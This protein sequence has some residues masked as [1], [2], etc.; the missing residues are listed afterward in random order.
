MNVPFFR[1][2]IGEAEINEVV[3]CLRSGWLTSGPTTKRFETEFAAAVGGKYAVALNSA[4]AALHLAADALGLKPGQAVLV[5]TMT[6]AATAEIVRYLGGIP[7]LVDCD[8]K[9]ANMDLAD[10][11]R[12][13]A[14]LKAGKIPAAQGQSPE[15]VGII[16][17][18]VS[19]L[20]MNMQEVQAFADKHN[21][22]VVEDAAH[23]FPAAWRPAADQPWQRCGEGTSAVA[24]FSFY[25]NK[26]ITTG[27]GG[28]A[29]TDD[30]KLADRIRMM[31]LHGL[32]H[33]AWGRYTGGGSWDYRIVEAGYKYNLTDVA[34]A[35]GVHQLA[36]GEAM[37]VEREQLAAWY[38]EVLAD[39][40]AI[41]VPGVPENRIHSWHLFPIRLK[42]ERLKIDRNAFFAAMREAG[43]GCSVHWRP[44]H[45][46]PYYSDRFGWTPDLFPVATPLWERSISL[47]LFPGMRSDEREYVA[48][49]VRDLCQKHAA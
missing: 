34:A 42:L 24:C 44:L 1:P 12:K 11:E 17:V 22:W 27:E 28:M 2:A 38:R 21:L 47:P 35:I 7:I 10:A 8:A 37:R 16:P 23:A 4:T 5:P 49:I 32:S 20:M 30:Q 13:L 40:D 33:D 3:S 19:G 14:L 15:V 18:H 39:V 9:T 36:R 6:F 46:H 41:E 45:L 43:V 25:A 29:V 48:Q 26:T 31:S